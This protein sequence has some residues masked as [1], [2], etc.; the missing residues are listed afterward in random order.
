MACVATGH[1]PHP[2]AIVAFTFMKLQQIQP[3]SQ[4]QQ[5]PDT[6]VPAQQAPTLD[7]FFIEEEDD[8][9]IHFSLTDGTPVTLRDLLTEDI[10]KV[11]QFV[12]K[13]DGKA[14]ST[15][16]ALKL[17]SLLCTQWGEKKSISYDDLAKKSLRKFAPDLKRINKAFEFFRL[18]DLFSSDE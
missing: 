8:G 4:S 13:H 6:V 2:V 18:E 17:V 12:L 5:N 15:A 11:E 14:G 1:H 3:E 9:S 7:R 16:I 10:T